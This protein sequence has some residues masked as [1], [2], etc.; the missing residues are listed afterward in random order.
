[1]MRALKAI[2]ISLILFSVTISSIAIPTAFAREEEEKDACERNGG[3]WI[4]RRNP[5]TLGI[6]TRTVCEYNKNDGGLS[7]VINGNVESQ[8]IGKCTIEWGGTVAGL[9]KIIGNAGSML[10]TNAVISGLN[11]VPYIG[12]AFEPF[13]DAMDQLNA[14]WIRA[15]TWGFVASFVTFLSAVLLQIGVALNSNFS[16]SNEIVTAGFNIILGIVNIA[17]V[18][19]LIVIGIMVILRKEQLVGRRLLNF[20]IAIV[21]VNFS[22][23]F[24]QLFISFSNVLT[25]AFLGDFC[26]SSLFAAFNIANIYSIMT[27]FVS[28]GNP[29]TGTGGLVFASSLTVVGAVAVLTTAI[30]MILRFVVLNM[31][32][33]VMPLA[34]LGLAIPQFGTAVT[35]A[36]DSTAAG[37]EYVGMGAEGGLWGWWWKNFLRWLSIGPIIA[38]SIYF[39]LIFMTSS[40]SIADTAVK[41]QES[42]TSFIG[43][44]KASAADPKDIYQ[45]INLLSGITLL[46]AGAFFALSKSGAL[47]AVGALAVNKGMGAIS[48]LTQKVGQNI[49][50]YRSKRYADQA[51][52]L[53]KQAEEREKAGLAAGDLRKRAADAARMAKLYGAVGAGT[54]AAPTG[55]RIITKM[56]LKAPEAGE[57]ALGKGKTLAQ[58]RGAWAETAMAKAKEE[59]KIEGKSTDEVKKTVQDLIK[60]RDSATLPGKK[61]A[62]D[63]KLA[64]AY[65][66]LADKGELGELTDE[67]TSRLLSNDFATHLR[68]MNTKVSFAETAKNMR[69]DRLAARLKTVTSI[70]SQEGIDA[71]TAKNAQL[72]IVRGLKSR[73]SLRKVTDAE[74]IKNIYSLKADIEKKDGVGAFKDYEIA[75][76]MNKDSADALF[77]IQERATEIDSRKSGLDMQMAELRSQNVSINAP[78]YKDLE[79]K[80]AEIAGDRRKLDESLSGQ[81]KAMSQWV[82]NLDMEDF[83]KLPIDRILSGKMEGLNETI[84]GKVSESLITRMAEEAPDLIIPALS[85]LKRDDFTKVAKQI[86]EKSTKADQA[87]EISRLTEELTR[88]GAQK[89]VPIEE[90]IRKINQSREARGKLVVPQAIIDEENNRLDALTKDLERIKTELRQKTATIESSKPK[91]SENNKRAATTAKAAAAKRGINL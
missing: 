26:S 53:K 83:K 48:G 5:W 74:S 64:V 73:D 25:E 77:A 78:E 8:K 2:L 62:L 46:F 81:S 80:L 90:S 1:M 33:I 39:S 10:L 57:F 69:G 47:G 58:V 37:R 3:E 41:S 17:F 6:A 45:L 67:Q 42:Q 27:N 56:G 15:F 87:S 35:R 24:A 44:Q 49:G 65:K 31:L 16:V 11:G 50:L 12:G 59:L 21:A 75:F 88:E 85:K 23:F 52:K 51:E 36:V 14:S 20:V 43:V 60:E 63:N 76:G 84:N 40:S 86:Y 28:W 4:E 7:G 68:T 30:F 89:T 54:Q 55:A 22:L 34:W 66:H 38:F 32:V 82:A 9:G 72:E 13:D 29:L 70:K 18:I 91:L 61:I 19:G 71:E 79:K